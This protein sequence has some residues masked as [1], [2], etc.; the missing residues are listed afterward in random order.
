MSVTSEISARE[1]IIKSSEIKVK[2]FRWMQLLIT[3]EAVMIS[4]ILY[5]VPLNES[6]DTSTNLG[7]LY[8]I[9]L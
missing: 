6:L 3:L 7:L 5:S 8:D 2:R 9:R 1:E 4:K